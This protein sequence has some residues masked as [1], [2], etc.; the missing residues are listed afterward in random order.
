MKL[1]V[2]RPAGLGFQPLVKLTTI[3]YSGN[4]LKSVPVLQYDCI[5]GIT[6]IIYRRQESNGF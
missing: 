2:G 1:T 3:S 5:L 6:E 4:F